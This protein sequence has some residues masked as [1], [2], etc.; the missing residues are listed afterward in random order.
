M[1]IEVSPATA[2]SE[3]G[4][5]CSALDRRNGVPTAARDA[6]STPRRPEGFA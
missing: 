5:S 2:I 6:T 4:R 1:T 3:A